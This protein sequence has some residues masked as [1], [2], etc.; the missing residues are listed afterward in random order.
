[1]KTRNNEPV[2]LI[3]IDMQRGMKEPNAE[4]RNNLDS[5]RNIQSLLAAWRRADWPVVSVRHISRT[6][7]SPFWPG[8]LGAE[9]QPELAP[10]DTEHVVEK[11]VPDAFIQSGLERWLHVRGISSVVLVGV[12]TNNSVESTART[13]GNLSFNTIVISDATF[14]FAKKDYIGVRRSADEVHAMSLAN[15]DGEY[16]SIMSTGDAFNLLEQS[17][18]Q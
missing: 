7:G 15:I 6:K 16:A 2:A 9:F 13:G 10:L 18:A 3:V 14:T 5:E 11:S 4:K 8:Q 1:M 12:S 17:A